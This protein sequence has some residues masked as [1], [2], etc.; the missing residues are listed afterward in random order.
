MHGAISPK[1]TQKCSFSREEIKSF[2]NSNI[3]TKSSSPAKKKE[4]EKNPIKSFVTGEKRL[5]Q[6]N[7][8][9][10]I[11]VLFVRYFIC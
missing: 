11:E 9:I 6:Q 8:W 4:K 5:K 3:I 1:W 10:L 7:D 2:R